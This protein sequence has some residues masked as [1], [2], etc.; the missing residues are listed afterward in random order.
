M[1]S[2]VLRNFKAACSKRRDLTDLEF[3]GEAQVKRGDIN[4]EDTT[5]RPGTVVWCC[6]C[7]HGAGISLVGSEKN[8]LGTNP[9][10]TTL[11]VIKIIFGD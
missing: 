3:F 4:M 8:F 1:G 10:G 6:F 9:F 5:E 2:Q 11:L 7:R